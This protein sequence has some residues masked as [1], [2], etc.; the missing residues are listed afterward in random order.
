MPETEDPRTALG[1]K[2][3]TE[4]AAAARDLGKI[5]TFDDAMQLIAL[6]KGDKSPSVQLHAA[7]AAGDIL[8]RTELDAARR[9]AVIDEVKAFDPARNPS[10]LMALGAVVDDD[11]IGRLGRLLRDPRSGVR[12][13]AMAALKRMSTLPQAADRLPDA[14]RRWLLDGRHPPDAIADLVRLTVEAGWPGMDEAIA[15]SASKGRA[16]AIAV[17]EALDWMAARSDPS[18]WVGV[19][20]AIGEARITDWLYLE[21]GTV[22]GPSGEL[23]ALTVTDGVGQIAGGPTLFRVR[24][25]RPTDDAPSEALRIDERMLYHLPAREIVKRFEALQ[26]MITG[27][28]RAALGV[29]RELSPLEGVAAVRARAASLWRGGALADASSVLEGIIANEA[30]PKPDVLWMLGNVQLASGDRDAA[31]ESLKAC[32]AAQKKSPYRDQAE[33]LLATLEA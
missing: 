4:R 11:G 24:T 21:Q 8:F 32:I 13:G 5:G 33:A 15:A 9:K 18:T 31:R 27:C 30:R 12:M 28:E 16:A 2:D 23:G 17:Q 10:L 14:V 26:P 19:W 3:V 6:A 25:G 20:A 22:W 1:S 29:A 7:G